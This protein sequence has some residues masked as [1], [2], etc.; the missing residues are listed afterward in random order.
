MRLQR[1]TAPNPSPLTGTG[2][3]SWVIA[4]QGEVAVIDPGPAIPAHL[5]ALAEAVGQAGGRLRA[6]LVTHAHLDH[7]EAAPALAEATGAP[8][9][10]FGPAGAG[11]RPQMA[12]LAQAGLTS[13]EGLDLA[14][15]PGR[16]LADG[17]TLRLGALE[18][19]ALHTP[20]HSAGHLA[21]ACGDLLFSG[22]HVMGWS[23]SLV[24]P[25]D[26][27]MGAYM[28]SLAR[29]QGRVWQRM[30]PGHG[31]AVED[32]AARLAELIA[33]RRGREAAVLQALSD[34]PADAAALARRIYHDTPAH[35]LPAAARNVLAHLIDLEE[36]KL[37][38][39]LG[40][41]RADTVFRRL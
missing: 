1:V 41:I 23:S 20:G 40:P 13:A 12:A 2:T 26:G 19:A 34:G 33:H 30:L 22:D 7:S 35:L 8:V 6:I 17:E 15:R 25:P 3:N 10:A 24:S 36:R 27:D 14:F 16:S 21:F 28:A 9:L 32:P 31:P 4:S 18:I 37:A 38:A 29:L 5:Q 39:A 11:R